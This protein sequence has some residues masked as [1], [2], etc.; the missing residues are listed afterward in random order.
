MRIILFDFGIFVLVLLLRIKILIS[1]TEFSL[2]VR[3]TLF[4]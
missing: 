1:R 2:S 3:L 4:H